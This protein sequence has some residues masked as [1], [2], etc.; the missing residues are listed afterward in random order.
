MQQHL[1]SLKDRDT[2]REQLL[3][4][5]TSQ[6][7]SALSELQ[8]C[9]TQLDTSRTRHAETKTTAWA[10]IYSAKQKLEMLKQ[11]YCKDFESLQNDLGTLK[12]ER[13]QER[14][15]E[16]EQTAVKVAELAQEKLQLESQLT[17]TTKNLE[18]AEQTAATH[19]TKVQGLQKTVNATSTDLKQGRMAT[20][21]VTNNF[22]AYQKTSEGRIRK[23][24]KQVDEAKA[25]DKSQQLQ[26]EL[27]N[28]HAS[29]TQLESDVNEPWEE[30]DRMSLLKNGLAGLIDQRIMAVLSAN[31]GID[32]PLEVDRDTYGEL[33]DIYKTMRTK[34]EGLRPKWSS[35]ARQ[36]APRAKLLSSGRPPHT[37]RRSL[38]MVPNKKSLVKQSNILLARGSGA[39]SWLA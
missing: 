33:E 12:L 20:K 13:E 1:E 35:S 6:K 38:P 5:V 24:Q 26:Q 4:D 25:K 30:N 19:N 27:D 22:D 29:I 21:K 2:R 39:Q 3:D 28:C 37:G 11:Q 14:K 8:K 34:V 18:E 32:P 10:N 17:A 7:G 16:K 23:L 31:V 15:Q 9:K 36:I